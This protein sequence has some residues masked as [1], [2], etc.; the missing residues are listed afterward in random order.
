VRSQISLNQA[1]RSYSGPRRPVRGSRGHGELDQA[2]QQGAI[3]ARGQ[4]LEMAEAGERGCDPADHRARFGD[5]M[6]VVE[7]VADDRFAG[8]DEA[9]RARRRHAEVMHRL[10]AQ[11]LAD[12]R[13]QHRAAVG[14]ARVRRR[15]GALELQFKALPLP[16]D[17]FA[18]QDRPA[19]AELS[20][21]LSEL[22][23]TVATGIADHAGQQ[24]VAGQRGEH[25]RRGHRLF[26]EIERCRDLARIGEQ[27]RRGDRR[28]IDRRPAGA[29]DLPRHVVLLGVTRQFA[30]ESGYRR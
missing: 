24:S 10:A 5:R 23:A 6:P 3:A 25:F 20:G 17:R 7:H 30:H 9:Q 13:A 1:A 15:A 8:A 12:R 2:L 14:A 19:V 22:V 18:E 4:Q 21:P 26:V 11:E 28:R 27:A 29:E 16:V